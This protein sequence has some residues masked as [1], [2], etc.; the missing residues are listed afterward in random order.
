[1]ALISTKLDGANITTGTV[2]PLRMTS[3][4]VIQVQRV[5]ITESH[6]YSTASTSY[7]STT[8]PLLNI[9]TKIANSL[10]YVTCNIPQQ[11]SDTGSGI[12]GARISHS[13]D[14]YASAIGETLSVNYL[15][16]GNNGWKMNSTL[17][18][19][20]S[21]SV[22]AGT[23]ITYDIMAKKHSGTHGMY[24]FDAWGKTHKYQF[25][26]MEIAP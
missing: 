12:G 10:I 6:T 13:L 18:G 24:A 26:A 4:S 19:W 23:T 5:E 3:G 11:T 21:P 8:V 17:E 7:A 14:S 16:G 15:S 1:M 2:N 20:H 9:T 22:A 25:V